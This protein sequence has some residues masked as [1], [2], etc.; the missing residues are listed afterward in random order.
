MLVF[1]IKKNRAEGFFNSS[2]TALTDLDYAFHR[3]E[4]FEVG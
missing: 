2:V 4:L 1:K 3:I